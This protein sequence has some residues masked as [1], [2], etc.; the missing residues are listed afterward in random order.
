M[1]YY[2]SSR[3]KKSYSS[4]KQQPTNSSHAPAFGKIESETLTQE[5]ML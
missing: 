2:T 5:F 1:L 4:N 3:L